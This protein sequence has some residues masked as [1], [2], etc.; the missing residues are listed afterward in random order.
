LL[1]IDGRL[2]C[3]AT[4][5]D[6]GA[7]LF[8]IFHGIGAAR[9][10]VF[11]GLGLMPGADMGRSPTAAPMLCERVGNLSGDREADDQHYARLA[12]N[13]PIA[14]EGSVPDHVRA[15]LARDFGPLQL[16]QGG[17]WLLNLPLARTM[18]RG[19]A[20]EAEPTAGDPSPV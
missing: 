4:D 13:N 16:E 14:P 17:E 3:I 6:N 9:V 10:D 8:G 18:T 20:F 11:D 2:Y 19:P 5:V 12:S 1:P 15:H 7:L